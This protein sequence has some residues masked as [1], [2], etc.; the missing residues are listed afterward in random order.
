MK[1]LIL[2]FAFAASFLASN[3]LK[4]QTN[5]DLYF[6]F[7]NTNPDKPL[8]SDDEKE[9]LQA[10]HMANIEKL[11]SE[12]KL[13]A[14]GPFDG[15]G[16]MFVLHTEDIESAK[17]LVYSDPAVKANRF[18]IEIY[19]FH[20]SGNDLC[21]AKEP[22]EMVTY[23]FVKIISNVEWFGDMD[24]MNYENRLFLS[25]LN[26]QTDDV[27]VYGSFSEY[28]DG[29]LILDV[30]TTEEAETIFNE[31]PSVKAGQLLYEV[32]P[33]WIAKGTFCKR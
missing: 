33:I 4:A 20:I 15:G 6:V 17:E 28:N 27:I 24:E 12:G 7:L 23:Q 2:I 26:N 11:A 22:Y 25:N 31:H 14:A 3:L 8:I 5:Q 32:K 10:E 30:P 9:K 18:L 21:G 16:G 29:M 19:P 1:N 13:L